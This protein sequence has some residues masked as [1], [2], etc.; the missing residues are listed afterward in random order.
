M[1]IVLVW[2]IY[3]Y[4]YMNIIYTHIFILAY[5][6]SFILAYA[7]CKLGLRKVMGMDSGVEVDPREQLFLLLEELLLLEGLVGLEG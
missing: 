3:I 7:P 4:V 6:H 2:N 1:H 5:T